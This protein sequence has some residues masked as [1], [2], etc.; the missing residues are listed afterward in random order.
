MT[1]EVKFFIPK[2]KDDAPGGRSLGICQEVCR[3]KLRM[4]YFRSAYL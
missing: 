3:K 4:G 1:T 2:A